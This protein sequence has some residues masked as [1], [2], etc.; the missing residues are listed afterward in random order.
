MLVLDPC[1]PLTRPWN[2]LE[3]ANS[4]SDSESYLSLMRS[5]VI[6]YRYITYADSSYLLLTKGRLDLSKE[7]SDFCLDRPDADL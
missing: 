7:V 3:V 5:D 4:L 6:I 1:K 2:R